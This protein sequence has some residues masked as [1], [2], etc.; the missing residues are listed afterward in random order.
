MNLLKIHGKVDKNMAV[1]S[2]GISLSSLEKSW[3]F[4][5]GMKSDFCIT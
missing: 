2:K 4:K 3:Y 1:L 5:S